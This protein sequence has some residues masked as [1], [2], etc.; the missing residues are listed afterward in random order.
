MGLYCQGRVSWNNSPIRAQTADLDFGVN[1]NN[2]NN[3]NKALLLF[4]YI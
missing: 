2:D 4:H 3:N 1:I